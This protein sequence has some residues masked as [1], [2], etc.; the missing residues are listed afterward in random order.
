VHR[1]PVDLAG[2]QASGACHRGS[3][4]G[5]RSQRLEGLVDTG[6]IA[7]ESMGQS[8]LA[9]KVFRISN[10]PVVRQ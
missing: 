10:A 3:P 6:G 2:L 7:G 5:E 8:P 9:R 4:A 1:E